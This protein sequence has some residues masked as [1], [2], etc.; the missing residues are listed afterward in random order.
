MKDMDKMMKEDCGPG[1]DYDAKMAVLEELRALAMELM[2]DKYGDKM[3][4]EMNELSVA[5]PDKEGL[6]KGLDLAKEL[7][8]GQDMQAMADEDRE[9]D[10]EEEQ[11]EDEA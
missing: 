11:E 9:E 8:E 7:M 2:K 1:M 6:K 4:H 10:E 3:P 5:A